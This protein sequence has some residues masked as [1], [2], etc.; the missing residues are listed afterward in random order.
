MSN[1]V[2]SNVEIRFEP[3]VGKTYYLYERADK[4]RFLSILSPQEWEGERFY[5]KF[6]ASV[7]LNSQGEWE[8]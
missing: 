5:K 6:L 8:S 7:S 4:S 2:D 3:S 1:D